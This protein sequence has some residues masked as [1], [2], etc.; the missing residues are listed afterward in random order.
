V[1][2]AGASCILRGN[3]L[4]GGRGRHLSF[5]VMSGTPVP[6]KIVCVGRNYAAHARELGNEVPERPLLFLKPPSAI[7]GAGVAIELPPDSGRV[8]HEG[9]IAIVIGRRG[10]HVS[11]AEALHVVGGVAPLNDVTA[12][13]L[14]RLDVQ[15][16]RGKSFDTFCPVGRFAA[17]DD[18]RSLEVITRVNGS[19]RQHGRAA[20][21]IFGIPELIAFISRI[22]TLEVGDI[23]ATGT[24]E[25]VGPLSDGDVVEVEIPGLSSIRNPVCRAP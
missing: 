18:W 25:G 1:H 11:V 14:Q 8:E 20:D 17:H 12:R 7:I 15:F 4:C 9:E 3:A 22:M 6:T 23:I 24:P 13:D 19:V 2:P 21:M 10:R 16:T 5:G